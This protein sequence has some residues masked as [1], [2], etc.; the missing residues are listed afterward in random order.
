[1]TPALERLVEDAPVRWLDGNYEVGKV[2]S[3]KVCDHWWGD[4]IVTV[5]W[6]N[7]EK[8]HFA[9]TLVVVGR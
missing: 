3:V 6:K 5:K 7:G 2:V 4:S 9:D 1:M 8:K